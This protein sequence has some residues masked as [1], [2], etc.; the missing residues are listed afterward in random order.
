MSQN[1]RMTHDDRPRPDVTITRVESDSSTGRS[2]LIGIVIALVFVGA[3][4][5]GA[6]Q[7]WMPAP[8]STAPSTT[9]VVPPST[10]V[11]V[12]PP[13]PDA[14]AP[15]PTPNTVAPAP[16]AAPEPAPTP[17]PAPAPAP[18]Q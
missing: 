11:V 13:A 16:S 7:Y 1:D 6:R 4:Y 14:P 18:A 17:A 10:T 8:E 12:P 2:L 3:F 5:F 15:A 9:V